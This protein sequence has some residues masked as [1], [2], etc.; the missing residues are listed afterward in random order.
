MNSI[1][2]SM[3]DIRLPRKASSLQLYRN[4]VLQLYYTLPFVLHK[5]GNMAQNENF[6][7][8]THTDLGLNLAVP[9]T[10]FVNFGKSL[11]CVHTHTHTHTI[12]PSFGFLGHK[13][14]IYFFAKCL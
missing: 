1:P 4:K 13:I 10:T 12:H 3:E 5:K 11:P 7:I 2:V 6:D 14:E 8:Q 9:H